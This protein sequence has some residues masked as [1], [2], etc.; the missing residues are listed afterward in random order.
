[1]QVL[2]VILAAI[3]ER[4]CQGRRRSPSLGTAGRQT[5]QTASTG[6]LHLSNQADALPEWLKSSIR[7]I[8]LKTMGRSHTSNSSE[9]RSVAHLDRS[10]D[11]DDLYVHCWPL[12]LD[13]RDWNGH[14]LRLC[15]FSGLDDLYIQNGSLN[16]HHPDERGR[17]RSAEGL[18]S[19][20]L[21]SVFRSIRA[22]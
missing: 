5:V 10:T 21:D 18:E 19:G 9:L 7:S 12:D 22:W 8:R 17:C 2:H 13:Q 15:C 6:H 14:W 16:L 3:R 4:L 20:L 11:P 1:M